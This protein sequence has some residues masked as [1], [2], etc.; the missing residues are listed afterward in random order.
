MLTKKWRD[1][2]VFSIEEKRFPCKR[3]RRS[4]N[5]IDRY[6][7]GGKCSQSSVIHG[8]RVWIYGSIYAGIR[9][10][11][12]GTES[13]HLLWKIAMHLR[14]VRSGG[15]SFLIPKKQFPSCRDGD[16]IRVLQENSIELPS[17]GW[18]I[19]VV[20]STVVVW[21]SRCHSEIL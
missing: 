8:R 12:K 19:W 18:L 17:S 11:R 16:I 1:Y 2:T 7:L 20:D 5:E 6:E 14:N 4:A 9:T 10:C 15:M 3:R 13:S 21:A